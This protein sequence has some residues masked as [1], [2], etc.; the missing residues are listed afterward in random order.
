MVFSSPILF[1]TFF[2]ENIRAFAFWP[3]IFIK[4]RS[5]IKDKVLLNQEKIHLRQQ[6]ELLVI[7]FYIIYLLEFMVHL[8]RLRSIDEAYRAISFEREAYANHHNREYLNAR[9]IFNMWR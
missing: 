5:L 9:R 8:I 1:Q 3:F 7:P 2:R 4:H 6:R